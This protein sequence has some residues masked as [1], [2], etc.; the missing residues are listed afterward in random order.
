MAQKDYM[1]TTEDTMLDKGS[2]R[3]LAG[4]V[5]AGKN[6]AKTKKQKEAGIDSQ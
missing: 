4:D 1:M 5:F 3:K 2:V 6:K